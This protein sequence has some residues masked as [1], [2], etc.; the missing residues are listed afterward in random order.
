MVKKSLRQFALLAATVFPLLAGSVSLQAQ[1]LSVEQKLAALEQRSG[2]RLGVA[3]IDTADGSQIL[4]RGDERFAM[5]S[6]SKVMAA[7][8]VLKQSESQHDL[9]NQR[10][11]IKKGDLTNYNPIAE[12]HVGGSMSLSELSAAALQYSDNVAMNKLIAQLGGPQGVT[13]FARKIGD[14]TFRLDRTEPTLNTAIP[15]DPRDTTSPRAMAQTLRN[16]TLG[17][18][19]GDAQ[20]AKLVTWM[21]GNTTGT[22][23]IQA[24]LPASW[25]V[26][27]K[28][29]SGDYGTTNDIAVIWPKDRAPLVLVTYFTQPQ[30]EAESRRDVLASAAKIVTEGL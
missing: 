23:S 10:I 15:G 17:K 8:A 12:K 27:D 5:C 11:E 28:T 1:T 20:R 7:A 21:K 14:E 4:Y 26:G 24:G 22:A 9:L 16:L 13:A 18:A 3:L 2:G 25:V 6:T 29:G 30:P 19:L